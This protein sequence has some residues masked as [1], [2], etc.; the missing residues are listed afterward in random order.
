MSTIA[1]NAITDANDGNTTTINGVTPNSANVVGK[2]LVI[3]GAMQIAQRGTSTTGVTATGYLACDR[4]FFY[5]NAMGTWTGE[6]STD[7]PNEFA[8][9]FKLSC[10]TADA[11]P[12]V[13]DRV[14]IQH[15]IE[16]QFLQHLAKGTASA[17]SVTLSFWIKSNKTGNMQVNL[18]DSTNSRFVSGTVTI[19]SSAT[20][21]KKTIT[22]VGDTVS[23][24]ANNNAAG[25]II[26]WW[27]D[28]G[29][30][31]SSGTSPTTWQANLSADR[32]ANGTLALADS[33]SNYINITGVQLEVGESATEFEH[34]P[35]TT[36]LQ[37]CQRYLPWFG[38]GADDQIGIGYAT[39][40]T[41][42]LIFIPWKV[43]TR[44]APTGIIHGTD[45]NFQVGGPTASG[46]TCTALN[47]SAA[48]TSGGRV[49][50][51]VSSG[52]SSGQGTFLRSQNTSGYLYFTGCEL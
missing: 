24:F 52:L 1:V 14:I 3:N 49:T 6:Q 50:G 45:S 47:F 28:S 38:S 19:N 8:N 23:N 12:A 34:R 21:E 31:W 39:G 25:L 9:S 29:T 37:L 33:T 46:I 2:N 41:S 32:N 22:F 26:E 36:E 43:Q 5:A 7:A 40:S 27:F 13:G 4:F 16:G 42:W 17:K 18:Y 10:T 48:G 30:T 15:K 44:V 20:W 35:Y 11:S 51:N